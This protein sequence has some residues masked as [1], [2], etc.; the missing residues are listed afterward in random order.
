[1]KTTISFKDKYKNS[2]WSD[3]E[4]GKISLCHPTFHSVIEKMQN[5]NFEKNNIDNNWDYYVSKYNF[6]KKNGFWGD[7]KEKRQFVLTP[8]KVKY[9]LANTNQLVFEITDSCNLQCQYCYYSDL[10]E[11]HDIR[12][13]SKMNF[14][15]IKSFISFMDTLWE[16]PLNTSPNKQIY[17]SFYGGEPLLNI[18]FIKQTV[19]LF[20]NK[21]DASRFTFS[22]TTNGVL[23]NKYIEYLVE[24]KFLILVSLDGNENNNI[25]RTDKFG[26]NSHSIVYNNLKKIKTL[27]PNY[28]SEKVNISTVLHNVNLVSEIYSFFKSEF[29]KTANI[30][31]LNN[32]GIPK[33]KKNIFDKMYKNTL[34]SLYQSENYIDV[35]KDMFEK[36]YI[37]SNTTT[38]LHKYSGNVYKSYNDLL[39]SVSH[40][41]P[42]TGTCFPFSRKVFITV[43]GKILPC[44]TVDHKF[45][46]GTIKPNKINLNLEHIAI[47]YNRYYN[48]FSKVCNSC[49]RKKICRQCLFKFNSLEHPVCHDFLGI[50][51][52][53]QVFSDYI[54]FLCEH[55]LDYD[56]IMKEVI[57][58]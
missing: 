28:F 32:I 39:H 4:N 44:E 35:E 38:F 21:K 47:E 14:N 25:Y 12:K 53:K 10:Y 45:H 27:H 48:S 15:S 58:K 3:I 19:D 37:Y 46:L 55:P 2:Y 5:L 36:L 56:R 29:N 8:E 11:G 49:Y 24:N 16:S 9:E 34:D 1:M 20:K 30:I 31:E 13:N 6:L 26:N 57:I 17:I 33:D 50:E 18:N 52:I 43:N 40:I 54:T 41:S 7:I 22:M 51:N 23:L 42:P